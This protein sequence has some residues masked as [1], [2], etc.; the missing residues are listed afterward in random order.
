MTDM[1]EAEIVQ[2]VEDRERLAGYRR[3]GGALGIEGREK[4]ETLN[5]QLHRAGLLDRHIGW[6]GSTVYMPR[7]RYT[8]IAISLGDKEEEP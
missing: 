3:A 5:Q 2:A 4:L 6:E 7:P 8:R 1:T